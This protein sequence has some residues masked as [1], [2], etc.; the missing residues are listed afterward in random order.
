MWKNPHMYVLLQMHFGVDC[1]GLASGPIAIESFYFQFKVK[2]H[3]TVTVNPQDI[4]ST[5]TRDAKTPVYKSYSHT[6]VFRA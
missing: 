2:I 5:S 1:C 4:S 6:C 3:I